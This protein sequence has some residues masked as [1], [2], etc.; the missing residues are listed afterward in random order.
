MTVNDL[1]EKLAPWED[2]IV[3]EPAYFFK[4]FQPL[5]REIRGTIHRQRETITAFTD[6][7]VSRDSEIA[8]LK[9]R[10]EIHAAECKRLVLLLAQK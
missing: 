4:V 5:V 3:R 10:L 8:N 9:T 2:P 1:L 7:I 6:I